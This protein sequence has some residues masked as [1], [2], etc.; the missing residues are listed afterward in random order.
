MARNIGKQSAI[1]SMLVVGV[2]AIIYGIR[3][4]A[5]DLTSSVFGIVGLGI[6]IILLFEIG[7][8][9]L[10]S[11]SKLKQLNNQQYIGLV[12]AIFTI[13]VSIGLLFE[14]QIPFLSEIVNGAFITSGAWLILEAF[15]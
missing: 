8:K 7:I 14:Y 11:L 9:R 2:L 15:T 6:G 5:F 13:I 4:F 1:L 3:N 12:I 10:T